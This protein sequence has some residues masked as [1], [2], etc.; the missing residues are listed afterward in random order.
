MFLQFAL[1]VSASG[2]LTF[3]L[4][5]FVLASLQ[6][7]VGNFPCDPDSL[8]KERKVIDFH[9]ELFSC[10]EADPLFTLALYMGALR[11]EV[12]WKA[13]KSGLNTKLEVFSLSCSSST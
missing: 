12:Q 8:I 9:V 4:Q 6:S 10:C 3:G 2:K 13:I 11:P 1:G 7:S 5:F